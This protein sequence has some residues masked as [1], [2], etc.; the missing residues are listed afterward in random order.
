M[1]LLLNLVSDLQTAL[2]E[3]NIP[4]TATNCFY[5]F[6]PQESLKNPPSDIFAVIQP[7]NVTVTDRCWAGSSKVN[8]IYTFNCIIW[9]FVRL[10]TDEAHRDDSYLLNVDNGSIELAD[11][12]ITTIQEYVSPNNFI[13]ELD[14]VVWPTQDRD[15]IGWS[16]TQ[17]HVHSSLIGRAA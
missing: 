16:A 10:A 1:A 11:T 5:A 6:S 14:Q 17:L 4:F 9:L 15:S 13:Y 3:N 2:T 7:G 12:I 8:I